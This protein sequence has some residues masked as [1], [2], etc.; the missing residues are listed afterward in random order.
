[1]VA[2]RD[3]QLVA[4]E[5]RSGVSVLL[6]RGDLDAAAPLSVWMI[7]TTPSIWLMIGLALGHASLE[8]FLDARQT[9]G[10]VQAGHTA[11]VEGAHREL[12]AR[13]ADATGRR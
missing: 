10:D 4:F 6:A 1:M 8:Q 7:S 3:E 11:G 2:L 9:A 5:I 12:R 13:L